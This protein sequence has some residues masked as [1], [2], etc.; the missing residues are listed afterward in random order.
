MFAM[1]TWLKANEHKII[2]SKDDPEDRKCFIAQHAADHLNGLLDAHPRF[3]NDKARV[4]STPDKKGIMATW[5]KAF[6]NEEWKPNKKGTAN[7]RHDQVGAVAQRE[8]YTFPNKR[9]EHNNLVWHHAPLTSLR[10]NA[11]HLHDLSL[12]AKQTLHDLRCTKIWAG[13]NYT[14]TYT[15]THTCMCT[16]VHACVCVF[17]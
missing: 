7:A 8:V 11:P 6:F 1:K 3:K 16:C 5:L 9:R 15:H 4:A 14:H 13:E 2:T 10:I 17:M 12:L